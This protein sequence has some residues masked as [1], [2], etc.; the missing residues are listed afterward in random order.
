M[1]HSIE[2]VIQPADPPLLRLPIELIL[3]IADALGRGDKYWRPFRFVW[4]YRLSRTNRALYNILNPVLYKNDVKFCGSA[5]LFFG[6]EHG[7]LSTMKLAYSHGVNINSTLL[8]LPTWKYG[9][10]RGAPTALHY[11]AKFDRLEILN[12][13]LDHGANPELKAGEFHHLC[14]RCATGSFFEP[15]VA[16]NW[17]PL[18]VAI[19]Q[20]HSRT[21]R[22][23]ISRGASLIVGG[24][25][26]HTA[27]FSAARAGNLRIFLLLI[28]KSLVVDINLQDSGGN[29]VLHHLIGT[30]GR[31]SLR[32]ALSKCLD[33]GAHLEFL[34]NHGDT[35]FLYACRAKNWIL[36]KF[37][38]DLGADPDPQRDNP[39]A[40]ENSPVHICINDRDPRPQGHEKLSWRK[41]GHNEFSLSL[42]RALLAKGLE[43]NRSFTFNGRSNVTG[44][45]LACDRIDVAVMV[46]LIKYGA[47]A[48]AQDSDGKTPLFYVDRFSGTYWET[49]SI[50]SKMIAI[51]LRHGARLDSQQ[52]FE[53][54]IVVKWIGRRLDS[55]H[56]LD[57]LQS[58]GEANISRENLVALISSYLD[59]IR[60]LIELSRR[61]YGILP[62]N[63]NQYLSTIFRQDN[64]DAL[65]LLISHGCIQLV[66]NQHQAYELVR[67]NNPGVIYYSTEAL[68]AKALS[69]SAGNI[70]AFVIQ[71]YKLY[72]AEAR[73]TYGRTLLHLA[74][75]GIHLQVNRRW[76]V[77]ELL[78][79]R[80]GADDVNIFDDQLQTPLHIA[81]TNRD[82]DLRGT[83][84]VLKILLE[85][86]AYP[87]MEPSDVDLCE[88]YPDDEDER[89]A[90]KRRYITPFELAIE[91][92]RLDIVDV[93]LTAGCHALPDIPPESRI[94]YVH[95]AFKLDE[96][97]ILERL[98]EHGA[99]VNGGAR[100]LDPPAAVL[101][102]EIW[103]RKRDRAPRENTVERAMKHLKLLLDFEGCLVYGHF[104]YDGACFY[105]PYQV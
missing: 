54:D 66:M 33:L 100:C 40:A 56:P 84:Q 90:A 27:L 94:S 9:Y 57:F 35:P 60:Q 50:P 4:V 59:S 87:H 36:A 21:A 7:R 32:Q 102:R 98:M 92:S 68:L 17:S 63:I 61:T 70:A 75:A 97:E 23:L 31:G 42:I 43:V 81:V 19:C 13:L 6:T 53:S 8:H 95:R 74:V 15:A 34:N 1:A 83:L 49:S 101:L 76:E 38:L 91:Q 47:S 93:M 26:T 5:S 73:F 30:R 58:A 29:T 79:E 85:A 80:L 37:L 48:H 62:D 25:G 16:P 55:A 22:A 69:K 82:H 44:L 10:M 20:G 28:T 41:R 72:P 99:D 67:L 51:L 18:H 78:L 52:A 65:E 24:E 88:A 45:M 71:R 11:A 96:T 2:K 86:D 14:D 77:L 105:I 89:W 12:W 103:E 46:Q 3:Q 39:G 64:E 104:E